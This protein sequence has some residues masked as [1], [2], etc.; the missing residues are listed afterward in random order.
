MD[1]YRIPASGPSA[2]RQIDD[3]SLESAEEEEEGIGF[4]AGGAVAESE[5]DEEDQN[6]HN[7]KAP[8][9]SSRCSVK[10]LHDLIASLDEEK[11]SMSSRWILVAC[12]S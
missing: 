6:Q 12:W 2:R 11:Y 7:G 5:S 8:A 9:I 3:T 4:P 10:K 1:G